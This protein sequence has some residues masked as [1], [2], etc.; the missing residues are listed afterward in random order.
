MATLESIFAY[1]SAVEGAWLAILTKAG[2]TAY[3]EFSDA[4][5]K[6][7]FVD[8]QLT[9]VFPLGHRFDAWEGTLVTRIVTQRGVNS[10]KHL[11]ILGRVRIEAHYFNDRFNAIGILPNHAVAN[12]KETQL[13]RGIDAERMLD[14]SEVH[15]LIVFS[16]RPNSLIIG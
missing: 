10:D 11:D 15:H 2:L 9:S 14:W 4:S 12:L 1:E 6:T 5:K 13:T 3:V 16:A 7:P 8:V